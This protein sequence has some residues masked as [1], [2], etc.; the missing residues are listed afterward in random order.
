MVR[1]RT[2][3]TDAKSIALSV[4]AASLFP[5]AAPAQP[6]PHLP[7]AVV[8]EAYSHE[9]SSAGFWPGG[10]GFDASFYS[11][12][13]PEPPGYRSAR[14]EPAA[15]AFDST[16]TSQ[17]VYELFAYLPNVVAAALVLLIGN[18]LARFLGRSVLI[19]AAPGN[20]VGVD[21]G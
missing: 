21:R 19:G 12:A 7:D 10:N 4:L 2:V 18:V 8:R 13:Y 9:V 3:R 11:Y 20:A 15:A 17:L 5:L 16:L 6:V 14:I 1:R